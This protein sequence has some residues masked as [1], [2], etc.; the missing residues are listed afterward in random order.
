MRIPN[1]LTDEFSIQLTK[2]HHDISQRYLH[3]IRKQ[4]RHT[5]VSVMLADARVTEHDTFDPHDVALFY[6]MLSARLQNWSSRPIEKTDA[7]DLRRLHT[8]FTTSIE[9]YNL[10]CYYGVQYHSLLFYKFDSRIKDIQTDITLLDEKITMMKEEIAGKENAVLE[11]EF[12]ER[13]MA[14]LAFEKTVEIVYNDEKL[15]KE[16]TDKIDEIERNNPEYLRITEKRDKLVEELKNMIIEL[17]RITPVLIDYN[18]LMQ[19]EEGVTV[20]FDLEIERQGEKS[21]VIN[22]EKIPRKVKQIIIDRLK[23][24]GLAL[25]NAYA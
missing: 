18:K 21:G 4:I 11:K 19:G 8:L 14:N 2:T 13:G 17:H 24:M 16:L 9:K 25:M 1:N 12:E 10:S 22:V 5:K 3:A 23:E 20:Y 6:E 15:Y 7:G